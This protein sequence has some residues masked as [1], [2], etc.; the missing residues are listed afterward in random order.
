MKLTTKQIREIIAEELRN[1]MEGEGEEEFTDEVGY[2]KSKIAEAEAEYWYWQ[3]R[4][5]EAKRNFWGY[6]KPVPEGQLGVSQI[7]NIQSGA[8]AIWRE[9]Q[10][11]L[12]D[13]LK[14]GMQ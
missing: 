2:L 7:K 1:V 13:Y 11:L 14:G 10:E 8:L 12:D 5:L 3:K 9:W 6:G 4:K